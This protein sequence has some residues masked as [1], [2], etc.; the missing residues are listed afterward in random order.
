MLVWWIRIKHFFR[1]HKWKRTLNRNVLRCDCG[2]LFW[3][4]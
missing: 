2:R 3:E 1:G 4:E